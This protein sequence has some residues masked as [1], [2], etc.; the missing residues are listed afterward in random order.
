MSHGAQVLL[1][2]FVIGVI[3]GFV[4]GHVRGKNLACWCKADDP[5]HADVLLAIANPPKEQA[6]CKPEIILIDAAEGRVLASGEEAR[7]LIEGQ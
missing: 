1:L 7:K 3:I 2:G 6:W 5:C 4:V